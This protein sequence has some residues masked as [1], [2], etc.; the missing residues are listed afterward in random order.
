MGVF[1]TQGQPTLRFVIDLEAGQ[2]RGSRHAHCCTESPSEAGNAVLVLT[3]GFHSVQTTRTECFFVSVKSPT[4][5]DRQRSFG[6]FGSAVEPSQT[7]DQQRIP[8]S[9]PVPLKSGVGDFVEVFRM[10]PALPPVPADGLRRSL[11][12]KP[13]AV[14]F[15]CCLAGTW[16]NRWSVLSSRASKTAKVLGAARR[17]KQPV[18]CPIAIAGNRGQAIVGS[19]CGKYPAPVQRARAVVGTVGCQGIKNRSS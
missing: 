19:A 4:P 13:T 10:R 14:A 5:V 16:T 7:R 9:H 12:S 1:A 15:L 11:T 17:K 18:S 6:V 3:R 2:N 8:A